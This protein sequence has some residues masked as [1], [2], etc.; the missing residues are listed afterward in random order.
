MLPG[1]NFLDEGAGPWDLVNKGV[2]SSLE[3][4]FF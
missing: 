4:F 3:E 2:E 1:L